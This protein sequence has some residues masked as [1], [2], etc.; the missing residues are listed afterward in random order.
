MCANDDIALDDPSGERNIQALD[1]SALADAH[2][3][4]EPRAHMAQTAPNKMSSGGV[5]AR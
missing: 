4:R 3:R 1:H 5:E 2:R